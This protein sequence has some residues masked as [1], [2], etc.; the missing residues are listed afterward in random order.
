MYCKKLIILFSNQNHP[1][2]LHKQKEETFQILFGDL[3]INLDGKEKEYR[4]GEI[5][6]VQRGEKHSFRTKNGAILEEIS[7]THFKN[8]S[9]YEDSKITENKNRKTQLTHWLNID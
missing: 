4:P 7:T 8:D 3:T 5:V 9:F 6:L 2:H 1:V